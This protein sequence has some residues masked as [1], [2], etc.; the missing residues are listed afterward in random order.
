MQCINYAASHI[1]KTA[2]E[3]AE[4]ELRKSTWHNGYEHVMESGVYVGTR[5]RLHLAL[6][7]L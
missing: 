5:F 6:I 7:T 2:S 4:K 3:E 1:L